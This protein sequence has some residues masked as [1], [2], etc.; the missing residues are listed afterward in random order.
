MQPTT[1]MTRGVFPVLPTIFDDQGNIDETGIR[2]TLEYIIDAGADGVVYPGLASEWDELTNE[3]RSDLVAK[4]GKWIAGRCSF[5]VG[6][7]AKS[8]EDA[9]KYA[10]DGAA[11]GAAAAMILTPPSLGNDVGAQ[12]DFF[13]KVAEKSH[14]KIMLQNATKGHRR[15]F[16]RRERCRD[17][18]QY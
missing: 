6:A 13:G 16:E 15:W 17:S 1:Q 7:S 5:I 14:A 3:E 4:I 18:A 2:N 11:A 9:I 10:A 12:I 8:P